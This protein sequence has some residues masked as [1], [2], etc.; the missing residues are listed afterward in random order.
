MDSHERSGIEFQMRMIGA[1][2]DTLPN[3]LAEGLEVE[4]EDDDTTDDDEAHG[5]P[6]VADGTDATGPLDT[7]AKEGMRNTFCR[8]A[9]F[10]LGSM[11]RRTSKICEEGQTQSL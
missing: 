3:A 11:L 8:E 1:G 9:L 5:V 6:G 7:M 2:A 4:G 10:M